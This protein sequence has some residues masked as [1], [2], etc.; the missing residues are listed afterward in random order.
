MLVRIVFEHFEQFF[1]FFRYSCITPDLIIRPPKNYKSPTIPYWMVTR[2]EHGENKAVISKCEHPEIYSSF[3]YKVPVSDLTTG[4]LYRNIFCAQCSGVVNSTNLL[5]WDISL[6]CDGTPQLQAGNIIDQMR[7]HNCS[8]VFKPLINIAVHK[9]GMLGKL[10]VNCLNFTY[11]ISTCNETGL[12][13]VYD[14]TT[15]AACNSFIDPFKNYFKNFFCYLCNVERPTAIETHKC[16]H[17]SEVLVELVTPSF[18]AILDINKIRRW[19]NGDML[20]CDPG[21]Q[22]EDYKLVR[23]EPR[24]VI[25]NSVAF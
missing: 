17:G 22:F 10:G 8:A 21:T 11:K 1:L 23:Y 9:R 2:C 3:E 25:S 4:V 24:H 18:N 20:A 19:D 16:G 6:E 14:A 7:D 5:P 13:P 12:W 15:D